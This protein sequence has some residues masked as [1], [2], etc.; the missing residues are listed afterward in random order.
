MKIYPTKKE[1]NSK[2]FPVKLSIQCQNANCNEILS[3]DRNSPKLE[4]GEDEY[5]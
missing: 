3:F 4:C 2:I 1:R 5:L